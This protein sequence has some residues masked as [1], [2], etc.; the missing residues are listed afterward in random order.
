MS[1]E[2]NQ[3]KLVVSGEVVATFNQLHETALRVAE[4]FARAFKPALDAAYEFSVKFNAWVRGQYEL[5]GMP[6]GDN[7][8]GMFRWFREQVDKH[9]EIIRAQ[10]ESERQQALTDMRQVGFEIGRRLVERGVTL[11]GWNERIYGIRT[12]ERLTIESS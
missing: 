2:E 5:A 12:S 4:A 3:T 6:Y 1:Q 11:E 10:R 8:E 9:G 7:E